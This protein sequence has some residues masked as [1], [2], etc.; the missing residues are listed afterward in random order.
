ML[1][2]DTDPSRESAAPIWGCSLGCLFHVA[3]LDAI[4]YRC[5]QI[6]PMVLYDPRF[7]DMGTPGPLEPRAFRAPRTDGFRT[8]LFSS[9]IRGL[10]S[11]KLPQ[12]AG[13]NRDPRLE[14]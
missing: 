10:H 6:H 5:G 12:N 9:P 7:F 4:S 11:T 14:G 13:Q 8:T 3:R 1:K 2:C